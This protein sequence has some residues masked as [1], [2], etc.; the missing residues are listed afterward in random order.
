H[1][2]E[3]AR[4][5]GE[6]RIAGAGDA[7]HATGRLAVRD[8]AVSSTRIAPEPIGGIALSLDGEATFRPLERRLEIARLRVGSGNAHLDVTGAVEWAPEHYLFDV[9]AVLPATPCNDAISAIP[10][11]LLQ[12]MAAFSL[13]GTIGGRLDARVDSRE[14]EATTLTVR[15]A[16]GCR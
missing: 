4:L 3:D 8:L 5:D 7:L 12:E 15:V 10:T 14:L 9:H 2:S 6:L 13:H 1:R 11:D 16:D